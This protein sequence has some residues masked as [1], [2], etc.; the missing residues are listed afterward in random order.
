MLLLG[1][2]RI[3]DARHL[4]LLNRIAE[5]AGRYIVFLF[6][7]FYFVCLLFELLACRWPSMAKKDQLRIGRADLDANG[8]RKS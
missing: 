6:I 2:P 8:L 1:L 7:A 4:D 3:A 5:S